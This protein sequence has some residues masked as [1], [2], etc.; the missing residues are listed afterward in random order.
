MGEAVYDRLLFANF[1][2]SDPCG[3]APQVKNF[4]TAA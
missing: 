3:L 2:L 4:T 1:L